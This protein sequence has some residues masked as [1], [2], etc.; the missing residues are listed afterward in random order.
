M[1]LWMLAQAPPLD[2]SW[3]TIVG[4]L[5]NMGQAGGVLFAVWLMLQAMKDRDLV[6]KDNSEAIRE[7]ARSMSTICQY[8][9]PSSK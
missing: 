8:R 4:L 5:G 2:A 3:G 6:V 7:L 1:N 9:H